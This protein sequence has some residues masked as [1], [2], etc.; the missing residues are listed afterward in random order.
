L[1]LKTSCEDVAIIGTPTKIG[2]LTHIIKTDGDD[3]ENHPW[4]G[5]AVPDVPYPPTRLGR[6]Q[7]RAGRGRCDDQART[8]P[9]Q[10]ERDTAASAA[11]NGWVE[12]KW[13]YP[14][15]NAVEPKAGYVELAGNLTVGSGIYK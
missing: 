3:N 13:P 6:F 11:G 12:Y 15:T 2:C 10:G 1:L 4:C 9:D 7:G 8:R 14:S 5:T